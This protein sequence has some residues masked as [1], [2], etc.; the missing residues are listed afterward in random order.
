[1]SGEIGI[2]GL[3]FREKI[4]PDIAGIDPNILCGKFQPDPLKD[5]I[6]IF[7]KLAGA[8]TAV[9]AGRVVD[10][11]KVSDHHAVIPT[12]EMTMEKNRI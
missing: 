8:Y 5:S 1:M 2:T 6:D 11:S 10:S 9:D 12:G 4:L 7:P 3:P